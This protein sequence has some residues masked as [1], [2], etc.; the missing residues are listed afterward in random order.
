MPFQRSTCLEP[1]ANPP[2][3]QF[4]FL[5]YIPERFALWKARARDSKEWTE[6]IWGD[7]RE[8]VEKRRARGDKRDCLAD[9]LLDDYDK[10]GFPMSQ[11]EFNL[12][13]GE[14]I[15]GGA[16][17]SSAAIATLL[18]ALAKNPD[19]QK[20]AQMEI[21][22]V[23]NRERSPVWSDFEKLPY[24][25]ALVK[26]GL[27]WRPVYVHLTLPCTLVLTKTELRLGYPTE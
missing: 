6:K 23:C 17:T 13:L 9:V 15:E 12:L 26:E 3:D 24:I 25:N 18:L 8:R 7:A 1:G 27:R 22:R 20:K 2:V 10:N 4:P 5:K 11:T 14:M 21:D 16:D 19:I